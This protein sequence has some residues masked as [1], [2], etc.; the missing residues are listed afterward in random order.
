ANRAGLIPAQTCCP[1]NR[2]AAGAAS[3]IVGFVRAAALRSHGRSIAY[4]F[5]IVSTPSAPAARY[6]FQRSEAEPKCAPAAP[7]TDFGALVKYATILPFR[8]TPARSS[9]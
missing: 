3:R 1:V 5:G 7:G 6:S 2:S 4:G 9:C 8:S